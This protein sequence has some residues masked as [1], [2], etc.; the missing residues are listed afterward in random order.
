MEHVIT[1]SDAEEKALLFNDWELGETTQGLLEWFIRKKVGERIDVVCRVA[2]EDQTHTILS[3]EDKQL[4]VNYLATQGVIL[5]TVEKLPLNVKE[6]IVKRS[7]LP[8][9]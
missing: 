9:G 5:T 3:L 2:L 8:A 6:E 4:L 7:N 1:L